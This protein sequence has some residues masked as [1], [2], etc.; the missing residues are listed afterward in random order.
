MVR[1]THRGDVLRARKLA[2][3]IG[4]VAHVRW[5]EVPDPWLAREGKTRGPVVLHHLER[6]LGR[7]GAAPT[8]GDARREALAARE[9]SHAE[10]QALQQDLF[11]R[12]QKLG[13]LAVLVRGQEALG[14]AELAGLGLLVAQAE[15]KRQ[16]T[17]EGTAAEV[18]H[19]GPFHAAVANQ[20]HVGRAAADVDEDAALRPRFFAGASA[21]ERVRLRDGS[22]ELTSQLAYVV[23]NRVDLGH[24]RERMAPCHL[25]F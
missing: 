22:G 15:R 12:A 23:R 13:Y 18:E 10:G 24:R 21:R 14:M 2:C 11:V 3:G 1:Q 4:Q 25:A 8:K 19:P 9:L 16:A 17:G 7:N 20:R 6:E 5:Y